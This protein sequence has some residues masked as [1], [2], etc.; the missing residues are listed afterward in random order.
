MIEN[1]FN[2]RFMKFLRA[3]SSSLAFL[4][5]FLF[6]FFSQPID[7]VKISKEDPL[8]WEILHSQRITIVQELD[9][10]F[11]ARMERGLVSVLE[12]NH[13]SYSILDRD[14]KDREYFLVYSPS[15]EP[16]VL[17][18]LRA[19]GQ[20]VPV[21]KE[22]LL[23]W[24]EKEDPNLLLPS[25]FE[26]KALSSES[27]LPYLETPYP[28]LPPEKK[29]I[30]RR[31]NEVIR[32]IVNEVSLQSLRNFVQSL[33]D[34]TTRYATTPNCDAAAESIFNY[35]QSLGL[36]TKFQ[37]FA[38]R[39][40]NT[41][42][43]IIAE[44]RGKTYPEDIVI[45]CAHYDSTSNLAPAIA[46]GA[47][48]D[49]SGTAAVMEAARI[50]SKYPLDFSVR[51]IAFSAEELGLYGSKAYASEARNRNEKIIGVINLDMI[52]YA[53][54]LPEDFDIIVNP[55]S[56]WLAEKV[57]LSSEAYALLS[58]RKIIKSSYPYSDHSPFWDKGYPALCGIEDDP[59]KNPYYH[60]VTDTVDTLN[61]EFFTS[62][63]KAGLA[64]LADLSQPL[65]AGYPGTPQGFTAKSKI[66]SSL[67]NSIKNVTLTW[68]SVPG[69]V[70]YNVYRTG[71]SHLYYKKI[72]SS[73]LSGTFFVDRNLKPEL[74]YFYAITSVGGGGLE[75][76]FSR[77]AESPL[78]TSSSVS[79]TQGSFFLLR[80][81]QR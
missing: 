12:E 66:I 49:G 45:I 25:E 21:E 80:L 73:P 27:I 31:E 40:T 30:E 1:L 48:D 59:L 50:L 54:S 4:S 79:Q 35:F 15:L 70:G 72:N 75:S 29:I 39:T 57:S 22:T 23:F 10:C 37:P 17:D 19:I 32:Q 18:R 24:T 62:S 26:R 46:P 13:I 55:A 2:L 69:V 53:D 67:F 68:D 63:T 71:T 7:L 41:S 5:L 65:R 34:F 58:I 77:E 3:A 51:F 42:R 47:D 44:L 28:S 20:A 52:S 78:V 6:F 14:I 76:N 8:V 60:K 11:I 64:T 43:N 36:E 74:R 16:S 61:F 9:S 38:F 56:Q 33:Q 81:E